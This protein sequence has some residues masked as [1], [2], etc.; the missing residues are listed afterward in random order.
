MTK[1]ARFSINQS[2]KYGIVK[3]DIIQEINNPPYQD[4][5]F[6]ENIYD[7]SNVSLLTPV[8][9][10]KIIAIGLNYKSH[11]GNRKMPAVIELD[12]NTF[13]FI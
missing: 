7:L 4:Y 3:E 13:K 12:S 8:E 10:S 9:P 2:I 5:N 6:T 1:F 11:L